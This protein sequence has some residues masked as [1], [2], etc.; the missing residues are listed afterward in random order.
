MAY[1]TAEN[2]WSAVQFIEQKKFQRLKILKFEAYILEIEIFWA[3]FKKNLIFI[4][5]LKGHGKNQ[6]NNYRF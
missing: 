4:P 6:V 5:R 3:Y 2:A 1:S